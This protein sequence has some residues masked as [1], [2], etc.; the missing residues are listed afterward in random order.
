MD[1]SER[2]GIGIAIGLVVLLV[3][4]WSKN[5]TEVKGRLSMGYRGAP[6]IAERRVGS[7][8]DTHG[9]SVRWNSGIAT[10]GEC[11][12]KCQSNPY[13]NAYS[14]GTSGRNAGVCWEQAAGSP[15]KWVPHSGMNAAYLGPF[16]PFRDVAYKET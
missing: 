1:R 11:M 8:I 2:V 4:Y 12:A 5:R 13:C 3:W 15:V 10:E 9:T 7:T 14:W 16:S 6:P